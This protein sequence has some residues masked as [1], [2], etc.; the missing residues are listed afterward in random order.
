MAQVSLAYALCLSAGTMAHEK[1]KPI[2]CK[3][4]GYRATSLS[5]Y[6]L[7]L[8]RQLTR[9]HARPQESVVRKIMALLDWLIRQLTYC[10]LPKIVG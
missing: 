6:G 5:R 8:L 9:P 7:N 3:N 2:P 4:H 1:S 10:Q